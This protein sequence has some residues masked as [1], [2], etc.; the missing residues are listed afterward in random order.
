MMQDCHPKYRRAIAE[1]NSV[2]FKALRKIEKEYLSPSKIFCVADCLAGVFTECGR[3]VEH[4][5]N[6]WEGVKCVLRYQGSL[7]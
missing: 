1:R 6:L 5:M 4:E 2:V 3:F 7:S